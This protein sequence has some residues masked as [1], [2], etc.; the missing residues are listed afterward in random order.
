MRIILS[1][2]PY[3][4]RG[5]R[6]ALEADRIL[7]KAGAETVL[8]LPFVPKKGERL[9]LP[10]Q[11][12]LH[13][14]EEELPKADL[15]VC[16]GG[17][18]TILHAA[19]D[20]T[21]HG[22]P[23]LGVNMGSMGFMAELERSELAQLEQVARGNYTVEERMMLD[24]AVLRG[25]KVISR[26][27]AL[28]DAVISKGSVARVAELG[29][30]G[31]PDSGD[32]PHGG[33]RHCGHPHRLHRLLHVGGRAHCGAN[34]PEHYRSRPFAPTSWGRAPWCSPRSGR[35]PSACPAETGSI[36][37]C[38][39]TGARRCACP[40]ATGRRSG[41]RST[42]PGWCSWPGAAFIR[43]SIRS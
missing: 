11:A 5:L 27:L 18:G 16:F 37:T 39:R 1:S 6:T 41:A 32:G 7:R 43:S 2:N 30:A 35:S 28:N 31:G 38:R 40:A 22:V 9:D 19:R 14:L 33:R 20:A 24:V 42:A 34:L 4:D 17:D 13:K 15:L 3:R 8:C 29:G 12:A 21:L 26:D 36:C 10:R 23:I 25:E